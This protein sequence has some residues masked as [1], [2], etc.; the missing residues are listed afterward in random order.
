MWFVLLRPGVFSR[1]LA[2][3]VP[4]GLGHLCGDLAIIKLT[5]ME[6]AVFH[7]SGGQSGIESFLF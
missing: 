5:S 3:W 7:L 1:V 6:S 4:F 2:S